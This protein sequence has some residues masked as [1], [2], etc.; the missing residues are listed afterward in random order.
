[1]AAS[2]PASVKTFATRA[3]GQTITPAMFNDPDD[4]ITAVE[5]GLLQGCEHWVFADGFRTTDAV[6]LTIASGIV[7]VTQGYNLIDTEAAAASDDLVT[8]TPGSPT[9][10]P[11]I[12]EGSLLVI[13]P[14][15]A[16]RVVTVKN[17]SGNI[18]LLAGDYVMSSA[19]S[20]LLLMYNGSA[21]VEI[22]RAGSDGSWT[23]VSFSAGNFTGNGS[24]TW[25]L[26][27]GDQ[28]TFAYN[29]RGKTMTVAWY[30]VTTTV[31]GTPNT[32]LQIAIPASKTANRTVLTPFYYSDNGT[33]GVGFA[34]VSA[35]G[36]VIQLFKPDV[37]NWSAA[38][39]ATYAYG[40]ITFEVQ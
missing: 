14:V 33:P 32:A 40:E 26:A 31:G 34:Q 16:A 4:E 21:W 6:N 13:G 23:S 3:N 36:T 35:S 22:A 11:A 7:T 29:L 30:L 17:G 5:Q 12:D 2:Y 25:T 37:S 8:I 10:G 15:N 1:M 38:T 9:N 18:Q 27:S 20:R 24:M 28:T 39:N 19:Y